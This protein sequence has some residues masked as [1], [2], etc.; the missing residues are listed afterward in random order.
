LPS[1]I[2]QPSK[3]VR[4]RDDVPVAGVR[5]EDGRVCA[6]TLVDLRPSD[7]EGSEPWRRVR[8]VHGG[9]HYSGAYT[10][11]TMG[12]FVLYESRLELARLLLA[13]FDPQ[14]RWIYAQP[15]RLVAR[16][17]DRIRRHVPDYLLVSAAGVARVVNVKPPG[18]LADPSVAE[19]LA[20]PGSLVEGHGWEYEVW[21]GADANVVENIR[22][23]AAYRRAGVVPAECVA[24]AWASVCDGDLLAVAERRLAGGRPRHEARPALMAL[25]WSGMLTTDLTR[26]LSG[27]SVLRRAG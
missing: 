9:K 16:I 11:A 14:V 19:A 10:S 27:D 24:R 17:G 8:S 7:F 25:L 12:G 13:D 18:R 4:R 3:G 21:S 5:Y 23:L 2:A 15:F 26:P 22:F 6:I 1:M 20:W